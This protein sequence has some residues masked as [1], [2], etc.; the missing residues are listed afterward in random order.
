MRVATVDQARQRGIVSTREN[1]HGFVRNDECDP[2]IVTI[3]I[4]L[5]PSVCT[6]IGLIL[7]YGSYFETPFEV[8]KS[9]GCMVC[10]VL[11][12]TLKIRA[13]VEKTSLD[14]AWSKWP[15]IQARHK[16][17]I[18]LG[19]LSIH[20]RRLFGIKVGIVPRPWHVRWLRS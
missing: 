16:K 12:N 1:P 6:R 4:S 13:T 19:L 7:A 15:L 3:F 10:V 2:V 9:A 20:K 5:M 14:H 11:S 8:V 18:A 17:D